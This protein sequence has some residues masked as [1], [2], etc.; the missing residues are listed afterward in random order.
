MNEPD[1]EPQRRFPIGAELLR[2]G[3]HV[4]V[5]APE[6]ES[7]EVV[8]C[9]EKDVPQRA[10]RLRRDSQGYHGG[11]VRFLGPGSRYGFRLDGD[12]KLYPDPASRFQPSG[13]HGMSELVDPS[14]F[15]WSDSGFPGLGPRGL[16]IYELHFGTFT[17]EGTFRAA[18]AELAELH[19]LG[20]TVVELMPVADFPGRF[21]WGYDGVNLWA[22]S[23]NYGTP[24]DLRA[25]VDRAHQLGMGVILDVVYNHFGPSGN[26]VPAFS[27][28]YLST[29][30]ENEW[31]DPLNFD[32]QCSA[33]VREFFAE[34]AR[35]WIE[36]FHLDGLRLDATQSLHDASPKHI[37]A[38]VV[39]RARDGGKRLGKQIYVVAENEPQESRLVRPLE[40][41]GYGCDALWNDDLH[42][43]MC[44]ALT[45]RHEAYYSDYRGTVQ[46]LLSATKWGFLYQGQHYFWQK[47]RRGRASLDLAAT[48][49]VSY[50]QN[51]DQVANSLTGERIHRLCSPA[52]LRTI[53]ALWLLSPATPMLFQGQ[54][55]AS[56]APFLFFADHEP[57]LAKLVDQGRRDFLSQF[58]S[59]ASLSSESLPSAAALET[60]ER[61]KLDFSERL[62]HAEIY[63]LHRDLLK[64]RHETPAFSQQR[65]DAVHGSILAERALAL[66]FVSS[67]ADAL[68]LVN[69]GE[70][71]ELRPAPDPLLAPPE[72]ADF[73]LSWSSEDPKYGGKG[74]GTPHREGIWQLP[75]QSALVFIAAPE[76][77]ERR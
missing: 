29:R 42:H 59:I 53:T 35:Y 45:G 43:S 7:V 38:E 66:R 75:A 21:G 6:R 49:Y 34:N 51:H 65:A 52:S 54:E 17:R 58:P 37:V 62:S 31:G 71:L 40:R 76:G 60:F 14:K 8:L 23:R 36:E 56:S 28:H 5:W 30:Y 11:A 9:D 33:H 50:L 64:L 25:F 10:E 67:A 22:P 20:V 15:S 74:S 57:E 73:R 44:V 70:D 46:E 16:V 55:F 1:T 19:A 2:G 61:C 39:E 13:P 77:D 26:Y 24:D 12:E 18:M 4:R 3:A 48:N 68:L 69:L 72:G 27:P 47:Q 41:G 32:G 63:A